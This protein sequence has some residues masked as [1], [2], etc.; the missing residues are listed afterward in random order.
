MKECAKCGNPLKE[1]Q[2][3]CNKCGTKWEDSELIRQSKEA[4]E[5]DRLAT[6]RATQEKAK[7]EEEAER[8]IEESAE[9][10]KKKEKE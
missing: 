2:I 1:D 5:A 4:E 10:N 7:K 3:F 8:R 6:S 9:R